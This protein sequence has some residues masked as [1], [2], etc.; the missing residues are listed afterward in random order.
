MNHLSGQAIIGITAT[1][2][3][4]FGPQGRSLRLMCQIED[5]N[6]RLQNVCIHNLKVINFEMETS[7][8][9]GLSS[10]LGHSSCTICLIIANRDKQVV[11][12]N[13][14]NSMDLLINYVLNKIC[15]LD[16]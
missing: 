10:L 3:G 13:Y 15:T 12:Y 11:N 4:F 2:V 16:N 6:K 8:L 5:L 1:A 9:Y 7:A 14:Q